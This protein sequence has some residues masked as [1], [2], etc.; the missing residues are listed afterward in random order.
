M[1][2]R[3][4]FAVS[5]QLFADKFKQGTKGARNALK[6]L[7]MQ[8]L[9]FAAALGAGGLG[10][11]NFASKLIEV[12]RATN[13]VQTALKNVSGSMAQFAANN[14]FLIDLSKKYGVEI[15]SLTSN[16]AKFTAA[17]N[18]SGM[19]LLDQQKLFESLSRASTAFGLSTD[20]TNGMFLAITQM[21]SKGTVQAEELRGQLGERLPIAMQAMAKAA[22]VSVAGLDDLM[23]KGKLMSADVLPKFADALNGLIPQAD[24]D[25]IETS[26]NRLK[27]AFAEFTKS[28]GVDGL[29][30]KLV[31]GATKAIKSL[32][33]NIQGVFTTLLAV[34]A[35]FV[36]NT[37]T[38]FYRG[39]DKIRLKS[40]TAA[41]EATG[42]FAKLSAN[43]Q[44]SFAKLI[45]SLNT[46]L[47]KFAPALI[48]SGIVELIGYFRNLY[49]ES[50]RVKNIFSD[51]SKEL[52]TKS[53]STAESDNLSTLLRIATNVESS[54]IE[55]KKAVEELNKLLDSN[56]S[57][58]SKT[59]TIQGDINKVVRERIKMLENAAKLD[60]LATKKIELGSRK[61]E[62]EEQIKNEGG[63][64][65]SN[66]A[67]GNALKQG[68][69][70]AKL[71][72]AEQFKYLTGIETRQANLL[73][74]ELEEVSKAYDK[75]ASD[76]EDLYKRILAQSPKKTGSTTTTVDP[77][78]PYT[79]AATKYQE[80][81]KALENQLQSG[82]ITTKEYKEAFDRLNK[83]AYQLIGSILG[84]KAETDTLFKD[85]KAKVNNPLTHERTGI[86]KIQ[87]DYN[88]ERKKLDNQLKAGYLSLQSYREEVARLASA[89]AQSI[90]ILKGADAAYNQFYQSLL[91]Q[92][93]VLKPYTPKE[94]DTTFDYKLTDRQKIQ[95]ELE[96][97]TDNYNELK[98]MFDA[99][100]SEVLAD[101]NTQ[102][103]KVKSLKDAL[104]IAEVK[105]DVKELQKEL[106][107]GIYNN[108]KSI[109]TAADR[110]HG[111]FGSLIDTFNDADSSEFEKIV[112]LLNTMIQITDTLMST[113]QTVNDLTRATT[114][115]AAAK[116][117]EAGVDTQTT[118]TK[119]ANAT[120]GMATEQSAAAVTVASSRQ[121]VAANTASAAS[122]AGKSAAKLPF[123]AN[124]VAI[125]A[126]IAGVL[127]LFA[128]IPKFAKGG[129]VT[130]PTMG[131]MGEY[132]GASSNPEVIAP[133]NKLKSMLGTSKVVNNTE[134]AEVKFR[135]DGRDLVGTLNNYQ[136]YKDRIK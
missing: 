83:A 2:N 115:L 19:A 95:A 131:L 12:A 124:L 114:A 123:P 127:A 92:F 13:K 63:K 22:G 91:K 76:Y 42:M 38:K 17:A 103:D 58:D 35:F 11:S 47:R 56:F 23:K 20:E 136:K 112:A 62:L 60:Y 37:V 93:P 27:N 16:Y 74:Q 28:T 1:A 94:R 24:T 7:Q 121:E 4:T 55:R 96:I 100:A 88:T 45:T 21:M 69:E 75:V 73:W 89:T 31:D 134:I 8:V 135:I 25:N 85:L 26:I 106:N 6:S 118:A 46:T 110:L 9:S 129:I 82:V 48:I 70:L 44:L 61:E 15:N 64:T 87:F 122:S 130:G 104:K 109:A 68:W 107:K 113:V 125:T 32:Q 72:I 102:M 3:L 90:A 120:I 111:A 108:I 86:D 71:N 101:L 133:L 132:P 128:T 126:A 79:K 14:K 39:I 66:I 5:L 18:I 29:Y 97:Q 51:L 49:T 81:L 116:Q 84:G 65:L 99:G 54:Y 40:K 57:I 34:V 78:D 67:S 10:L 52:N 80:D 53:F 36:T 98:R 105:E 77:K 41:A 117:A 43:I 30:K 59:L 119:V 33:T 50:K